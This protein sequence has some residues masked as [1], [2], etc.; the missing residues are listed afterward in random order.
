M[1]ALK[2]YKSAAGSSER[3]TRT[4]MPRSQ[5]LFDFQGL[6][7]TAKKGYN[8]AF[9]PGEEGSHEDESVRVNAREEPWPDGN[10][11]MLAKR[12]LVNIESN[13]LEFDELDDNEIKRIALELA[14]AW[15]ADGNR[16]FQRQAQENLRI[17]LSN[18]DGATKFAERVRELFLYNHP[19]PTYIPVIPGTPPPLEVY[20]V[21]H[22]H[23]SPMRRFPLA[24][25]PDMGPRLE[26]AEGPPP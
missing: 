1:H 19:Q 18:D 21:V 12:V 5:K 4:S 9:S 14:E 10:L 6:E 3:S 20:P 24:N 8:Q 16:L 13:E 26:G 22:G 17:S 2:Q 11:E 7:R 15:S 23:E 25:M